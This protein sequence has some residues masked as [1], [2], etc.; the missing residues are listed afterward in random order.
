M[1]GMF[2]LHGNAAVSYGSALLHISSVVIH[3]LLQA[4][5]VLL[6]NRTIQSLDC[7]T[8]LPVV[9]KEYCWVSLRYQMPSLQV[10]QP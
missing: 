6:V 3:H 1:A 2:L 10:Y 9:V 8:Y 7:V 5:S 4:T